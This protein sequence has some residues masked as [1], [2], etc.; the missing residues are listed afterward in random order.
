[1]SDELFDRDEILGGALS[2]IRR[3]RA[4]LYLIEQEAGRQADR[5]WRVLAMS[6]ATPELGTYGLEALFADD[7]TMR[8]PLPGEADD[9]Y[10]ESFRNAR[11]IS[12]SVTVR[13]MDRSVDSW[14]VLIPT[15]THLRAEV[16]HQLSIRHDLPE[17]QCKKIFKAFGVGSEE[18]DS[19]FQS[20]AGKPVASITVASISRFGWLHRRTS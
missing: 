12:P 1:M 19:A 13:M 17:N 5:R 6:T 4:C 10:V 18:F 16:L 9:A 3:A 20:V 2:R 11:R 7:E 15:T 8:G 14:Q